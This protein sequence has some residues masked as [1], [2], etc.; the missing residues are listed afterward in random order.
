VGSLKTLVPQ[1]DLEIIGRPEAPKPKRG[2]SVQ[3]ADSVQREIHLRQ[4]RA[5]DAAEELERFLDDA[6]LAGLHSV[7]IVHGKGGGVLRRVTQERLRAHPHVKAFRDADPEEGG[8]GVTIA[9]FD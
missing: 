9:E 4:M 7:R 8:Q 5:E 6:V 3:R 2:K 1:T